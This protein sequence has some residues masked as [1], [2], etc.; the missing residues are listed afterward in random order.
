MKYLLIVLI[1]ICVALGFLYASKSTK[2]KELEENLAQKPMTITETKEI[3]IPVVKW[4]IKE[5]PKIVKEFIG[6]RDVELVE[7]E[8][9]IPIGE[10]VGAKSK[11]GIP[12]G[13]I[14]PKDEII[15]RY[16]LVKKAKRFGLLLE[17]KPAIGLSYQIGRCNFGVQHDFELE[18]QKVFLLYKF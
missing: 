3:K 7:V 12:E 17:Y 9:E 4:K 5:V 13:P 6:Y 14:E 16:Q 2:I 15:S 11:G 8:K 18:K 10:K 1:V